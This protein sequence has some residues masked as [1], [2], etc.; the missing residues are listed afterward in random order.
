M[1]N[2]SATLTSFSKIVVNTN[3]FEFIASEGLVSGTEY[4][5]KVRARN[6]Y[7]QYYSEHESAPWSATSTFYSSNLPEPVQTLTFRD[8][9]KTGATIAWDHHTTEA[10]RGFS[11][12]DVF[13]LLYV[14]NCKS[15]EHAT[16]SN[17][18][19]NSTTATDYTVTNMPPGSTC[20]F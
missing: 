1:I 14:D 19:V 7:T 18:L 17:M 2:E 4:K 12:I 16:I 3:T 13:Y 20:R 6:F 9:S 8:R 10:Q 5:V 15:S 11:T